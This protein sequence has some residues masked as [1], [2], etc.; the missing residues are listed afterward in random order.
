MLS[1]SE[2]TNKKDIGGWIIS[3]IKAPVSIVFE[4][5]K[6]WLKDELK[7]L[8]IEASISSMNSHN[9]SARGVTHEFTSL[10]VVCKANMDRQIMLLYVS[11]QN[12]FIFIV[13]IP[14]HSLNQ[15]S[16]KYETDYSKWG[17][18]IQRKNYENSNQRLRINI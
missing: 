1:N 4:V 10:Q 13:T 2:A 11:K 7:S 5:T 8:D 12:V 17:I 9:T 16:D 15:N 3:T 6:K 14:I 18:F